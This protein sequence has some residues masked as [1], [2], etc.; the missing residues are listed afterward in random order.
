MG[1]QGGIVFAHRTP[2]T[3]GTPET[4]L[5]PKWYAM[6]VGRAPCNTGVYDNWGIVA[7][8]VNGI[9]GA[10][11]KGGFKSKVKAESY[12]A[13]AVAVP[14]WSQPHPGDKNGMLSPWSGTSNI[15]ELMLSQCRC[16]TPMVPTTSRRQKWYVVSMERDLKYCGADDNW[17]EVAKKVVGV[18]GVV[19]Q[20]LSWMENKAKVLL[21]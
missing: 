11:F 19:Y 13:N 14:P 6:G 8:H 15:V 5:G 16:S 18:L 17:P 10:L 21:S 3:G 20:G 9:S 12:L 4:T 1:T 2:G 7:P